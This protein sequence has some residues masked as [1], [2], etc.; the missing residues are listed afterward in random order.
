MAKSAVLSSPGNGEFT[1]TVTNTGSIGATDVVVTD[2]V[3]DG[4][5]IK[6]SQSAAPAGTTLVWDKTDP[7][8]SLVWTIASL[9]AGS[10][11][12]YTFSVQTVNNQTNYVNQACVAATQTDPNATNN[13]A[14]VR[15]C[16]AI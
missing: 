9:P 15:P 6:N 12:S 16:S 11:I 4:Y 7:D 8:E 14:T 3:P 2:N 5:H 10:S 13:C 1:L